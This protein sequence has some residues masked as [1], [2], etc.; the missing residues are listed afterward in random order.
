MAYLPKV[1]FVIDNSQNSAVSKSAAN[2][3]LVATP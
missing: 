2:D 3:E 1:F